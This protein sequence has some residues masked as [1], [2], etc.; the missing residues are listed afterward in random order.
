MRRF[1]L[2]LICCSY[3]ILFSQEV[4]KPTVGIYQSG[5]FPLPKTVNDILNIETIGDAFISNSLEIGLTL[6]LESSSINVSGVFKN[7]GTA[8]YGSFFNNIYSKNSQLLGGAI[9]YV[10]DFQKMRKRFNYFLIVTSVAEVS[11]NYQNTFLNEGY[12]TVNS[13]PL[14]S[15][16]GGAPYSVENEVYSSWFY[17]STPFVLNFHFGIEYELI[18]NL[19]I[20]FS[21]GYEFRKMKTKY[22]DWK[23]SEDVINKLKQVSINNHNFHLLDFQLGLSYSFSL[24]K[25]NKPQ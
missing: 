25:K 11:T 4:I 15:Y 10:F 20:N 24:K 18:R 13:I 7:V 2:F 12:S 16:S 3:S 21:A 23:Y 6:R 14:V 22:T 19:F 5:A 17:H 1:F 9:K 8:T